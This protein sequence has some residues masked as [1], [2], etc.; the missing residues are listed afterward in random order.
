MRRTTAFIVRRS[1]Y[2]GLLLSL[3]STSSAAVVAGRVVDREGRPVAGAEVRIWQKLPA[4]MGQP[5]PDQQVQ[6]TEG[7]GGDVLHTDV[8]GRFQTPD[9]LVADAFARVFVDA[10]GMLTAR[11]DWILIRQ[12]TGPH[13][14]EV[15]LR[16][17]RIVAGRVLD[18]QQRPV[19]GAMVFHVGDATEKLVT[20]TDGDGKFQLPLVPEGRVFIFAEKPGY[21]FTGQLS[22]DD[23]DAAI[24][25][26]RVDEPIEPLRTLPPLLPYEDEIALVREMVDRAYEAAK[27]GTLQQKDWALLAWAEL[28]PVGAFDRAE[29][30]DFHEKRWRNTL[31]LQCVK[32]CVAGRGKLSWDDLRTYIEISDDHSVV[33]QQLCEAASRMDDDE[34]ARRLQWL[35]EAL[36]HARHVEN[37]RKRACAL[38]V[39]G[40]A[41]AQAGLLERAAEI[42]TEAENLAEGIPSEGLATAVVFEALGS[43]Q[44]HLNPRG[45]VEWLERIDEP[46]RYRRRAGELAVR[47]LPANPQLAEDVWR[48]AHERSATLKPPFFDVHGWEVVNVADLCYRLAKIDRARAE[49]LARSESFDQTRIRGLAGV[50]LALSEIDAAA[51][52]ELL[53]SLVRD[54]LPRLPSDEAEIARLEAPPLTSAWLLP[55][56]ERIDPQLARECFWRSLA[57]RGPRPRRGHF[58]F[59][60]DFEEPNT[61]LAKMLARYDRE[62]ARALL[63]PM[64]A[65]LPQIAAPLASS[66][67]ARQTVIVTAYALQKIRYVL[68]AAALIDPRWA[69]ERIAS[70]PDGADRFPPAEWVHFLAATLAPPYDERWTGEVYDGRWVNTGA[71]GAGYWKLPT[72]GASNRE[73]HAKIR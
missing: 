27:S 55:I 60:D 36:L 37:A 49:R 31:D 44:A 72:A 42:V 48:R 69:V 19:A 15:V 21:R 39:V 5:L 3:C 57:L 11:T 12:E 6:F 54:E 4:P 23:C 52:R 65:R 2:F 13:V 59:N 47:L 20:P 63:E 22:R 18:C 10:E 50:A 34:R 71:Y 51:A 1:L 73:Y 67:N 14:I 24:T 7:E 41:F 38:A 53:A 32:L 33:A 43:A 35:D 29:A 8:D 40:D 62:V 45:A 61:E 28:D 58:N 30:L 56:A 26:A 17:L 64:A 16:R 25:L 46:R 70:L 66:P 68:I 9:V